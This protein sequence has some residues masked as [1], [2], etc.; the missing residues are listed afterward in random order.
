MSDKWI[1][2]SKGIRVRHHETRKLRNNKPD[3][4]YAI[5][6]QLDGKRIQES[7]GWASEGWTK[8]KAETTLHKLKEGARTGG[9]PARLKDQRKQEEI[10]REAEERARQE[11]VTT[12]D[13]WN[14]Y[15]YP[16]VQRKKKAMTGK[17]EENLYKNW[18]KDLLGNIPLQSVRLTD[19]LDVEKKLADNARSPRTVRYVMAVIS[20]VWNHAFD[21]D[22][23]SGENPVRRWKKPKGDNK[24]LRFLT[25]EEA[26]ALLQ[27]TR[28]RSQDLHDTCLLSLHCGLRAGEIHALR[29]EDVNLQEGWISILDPKNQQNRH[30]YI[31]PDT[32][33]ML[34]RRLQAE[35]A[36]SNSDIPL[37]QRL[38]FPAT[39]GGIRVQISD[40]F[41]RSVEAL[42]LNGGVSDPRNKVVFHTLRHTFAS[43]LVQNDVPIYTVAKLMGHSTIQMTQ[44]YS[45]LSP[46]SERKATELLPCL[47]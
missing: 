43:W 26:Q 40:A 32:K 1:T 3:V 8:E 37:N 27:E 47:T 6:F 44:R 35:Q 36:T 14:Q 23:V 38:I 11:A 28:S 13:Y 20:Q 22:M 18:I 2:L 24:R 34:E 33:I 21:K 9:A 30:A 46:S 41:V 39:N 4:Y 25:K 31:T 5:R 45:H 42:G 29:W 12:S 7:L 19:I 10:R 15:Y 17:T 16:D